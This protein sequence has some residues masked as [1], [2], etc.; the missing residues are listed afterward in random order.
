M[1]GLTPREAIAGVTIHAAKALGLSDHQRAEA[2]YRADFAVFD[3]ETLAHLCY[4]IGLAPARLV[5]Q[6]G[7]LTSVLHQRP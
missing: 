3:V 5:V 4:P 2:S 6:A 7:C 1:F